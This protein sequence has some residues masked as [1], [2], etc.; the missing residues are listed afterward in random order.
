MFPFKETHVFCILYFC[1]HVN[2]NK[3]F[4]FVYI[5]SLSIFFLSY[6]VNTVKVGCYMNC[7]LSTSEQRI[8]TTEQSFHIGLLEKVRAK[9]RK[10][11]GDRILRLLFD[12][13]SISKR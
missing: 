8:P 12:F 9:R 5:F 6:C 1:S 3:L 10:E 4:S 13:L 11:I 7:N 2:R